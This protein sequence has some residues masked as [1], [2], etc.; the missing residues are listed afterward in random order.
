[1]ENKDRKLTELAHNLHLFSLDEILDVAISQIPK[2][3]QSKRVSIY[4]KDKTGQLKETR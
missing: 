2:I 3:A 1:M 4:L